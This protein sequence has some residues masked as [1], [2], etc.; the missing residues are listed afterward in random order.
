MELDAVLEV[1]AAWPTPALLKQA[2]KAR[3]DAKPKKHGARRHTA[4]A[5]T[6]FDALN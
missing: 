4:W 2:G 3:I 1:L 6:I 5:N